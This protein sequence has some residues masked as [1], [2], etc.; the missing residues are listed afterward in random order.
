MK[1]NEK[2][3]KLVGRNSSLQ[4][5]DLFLSDNGYLQVERR[6]GRHFGL[7]YVL[8]LT[9]QHYWIIKARSTLRQ[10]VNTCFSYRRRQAPVVEQKRAHLP[11][12]RV[13]PSKPP[14]SFVGMDCFEPFQVRRARSS[15]FTCL[16]IRAIHIETAHSLDTS[17]LLSALRRFIVRRSYPKETRSDNGTNFVNDWQALTPNHLHLLRSERTFPPGMFD[18]DDNYAPRR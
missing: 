8:S 4:K 10:I 9:R 7:E 1:D 18:K 6:L 15:I 14:F 11:K 12:D 13:T 3:K 17:A 5:L 2:V 16:S